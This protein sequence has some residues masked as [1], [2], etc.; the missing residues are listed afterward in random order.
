MGSYRSPVGFMAS[1]TSHGNPRGIHGIL[2]DFPCNPSHGTWDPVGP[3]CNSRRTLW[4]PMGAASVGFLMAC[5]GK[6]RRTL[7]IV[8]PTGIHGATHITS[9]ES[10][11]QSPWDIS[12]GTT[13]ETRDNCQGNPHESVSTGGNCQQSPWVT[14]GARGRNPWIPIDPVGFHGTS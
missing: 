7:S 10:P 12:M 14:T 6:A 9:H 4:D 11:W 1:G 13:K 3:P 2:R 8:S 5:H